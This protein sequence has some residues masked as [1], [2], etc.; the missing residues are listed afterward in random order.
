MLSGGSNLPNCV[1][2]SHLSVTP[3]H[4]FSQLSW[5]FTAI[6]NPLQPVGRK[7]IE[8]EDDFPDAR[9]RAGANYD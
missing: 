6:P 9:N 4:N 1:H 8:G 2:Y 7:L 3:A 5:A